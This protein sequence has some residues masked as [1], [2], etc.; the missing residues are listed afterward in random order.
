MNAR[1]LRSSSSG[2]SAEVRRACTSKSRRRRLIRPEDDGRK[3]S[4]TSPGAGLKTGGYWSGRSE[5]W[6]LLVGP[7]EASPNDRRPHDER[8]RSA[9]VVLGPICRSPA[10]LYI[11][12][13]PA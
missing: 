12:V 6:R 8:A 10:C 9:V 5:D 7:A 2:L 13:A 11:E 3:P 4:D 1:D